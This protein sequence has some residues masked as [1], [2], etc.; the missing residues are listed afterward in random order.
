MRLLV[1]S[2]LS[3]RVA[4]QLRDAGFDATHVREHDL[5]H[6][7]DITILQFAREQSMVVVSEDT[8]FGQ[9]LAEERAATPSF[10]LL[11]T[12]EPLAPDE[13]VAVLVANLPAVQD[14][15]ERGAIVVVERHRIRVRQLPVPGPQRGR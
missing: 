8:D 6:S 4:R 14:D 1:D 7:T 9:L 2:N 5:Q 3:H 11:R 15:L 12:Y 10:V 13:Q